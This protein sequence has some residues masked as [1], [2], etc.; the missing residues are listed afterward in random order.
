MSV[1]FYVINDNRT[2]KSSI[3]SLFGPLDGHFIFYDSITDNLVDGTGLVNFEKDQI[4][5]TVLY[6][7]S[8]L[9]KNKSEENV[10]LTYEINSKM[11][12]GS[13][14][15][16]TIQ[17]T[18][19]KFRKVLETCN[20]KRH[21]AVIELFNKTSKFTIKE[22]VGYNTLIKL[23]SKNGSV[24]YYQT[25]P[26]LYTS[27]KDGII[28][29]YFS[30]KSKSGY[31]RNYLNDYAKLLLKRNP[32][33]NSSLSTALGIPDV[34][35]W[36]EVINAQYD[37]MEFN[38]Y[39]ND[40]SD[41]WHLIEGLGNNIKVRLVDKFLNPLPFSA[42]STSIEIH[43]GLDQYSKLGSTIPIYCL[44]SRYIK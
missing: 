11:F 30:P 44:Q 7:N 28:D 31:Y 43:S 6:D 36:R 42:W 3:P 35:G 2:D 8:L 13:P 10:E 34:D 14:K 15:I 26:L 23:T 1:F 39:P 21:I 20:I 19:E 25:D 29:F 4:V 18:G 40:V 38:F 24:I 16:D 22:P 5:S 27:T 41:T 37:G 12:N 9:F 17:F 33:Y 32:D